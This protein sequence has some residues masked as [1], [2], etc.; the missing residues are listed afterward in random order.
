VPALA[1]WHSGTQEAAPHLI[2]FFTGTSPRNFPSLILPDYDSETLW[3]LS[4]GAASA[5]DRV[6]QVVNGPDLSM[7]D[8]AAAMAAANKS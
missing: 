4:R 5:P 8:L 1:F 6:T 2:L 7:A 3:D